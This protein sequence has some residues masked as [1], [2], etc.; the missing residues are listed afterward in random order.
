[1]YAEQKKLILQKF[2]ALNWSEDLKKLV[3]IDTVD[4]YQ[5]KENRIIIVSLVRSNEENKVGFLFKSNRI[6]VAL[7]R[8]KDRLIIVGNKAMWENERNI[9]LPLGQVL[10]YIQNP[11]NNKS[12]YNIITVEK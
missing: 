10:R 9:N 8:A 11:Q 6:N 7:S 2:N 12:E 5:G 3:K 1:M 4:S